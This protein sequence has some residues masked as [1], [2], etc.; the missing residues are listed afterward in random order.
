MNKEDYSNL[1]QTYAHLQA[2]KTYKV[3]IPFKDYDSKTHPIGERWIFIGSSFLPYDDGL[4]LFVT[5]DGQDVQIRLQDRPEAQGD[6]IQNLAGHL[7]PSE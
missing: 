3:A 2:G 6:I 1:N 5:I 4:S 7:V